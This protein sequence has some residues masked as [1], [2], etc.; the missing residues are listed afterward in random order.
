M[1][2]ASEL[3]EKV[4]TNTIPIIK[5][6]HLFHILWRYIDFDITP[7]HKVHQGKHIFLIKLPLAILYDTLY[8]CYQ[9]NIIMFW[10]DSIHKPK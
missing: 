8:V 2:K 4:K 10:P 9:C 1:K 7:F 3:E 5:Y 6:M